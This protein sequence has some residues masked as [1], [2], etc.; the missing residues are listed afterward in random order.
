VVED[1]E[2][3]GQEQQPGHGEQ[4]AED[5]GDRVEVVAPQGDAGP[6]GSS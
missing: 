2:P 1:V 5:E 3:A 4:Q 6:H